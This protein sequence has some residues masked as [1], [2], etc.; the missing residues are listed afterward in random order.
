MARDIQSLDPESI[1]ELSRF[2]AAGFGAA[3]DAEFAAPEILRWKYF[4]PRGRGG[5]TRSF[6]A[7]VDGQIAG[8]IG[9][10]PTTFWAIDGGERRE[11]TGL[12]IIDWLGS[13]EHP[14]VG[15]SLI[16]T[17]HRLAETQFGMGT[18][19][20]AKPV[21][22]VLGYEERARVPI[23]QRVF[24]PSFRLRGEGTSARKL[25]QTGRDLG[26][27]IVR[28]GGRSSHA[29]EARRVGSFGPE[30]DPIV[31]GI[32]GPLV[33]T[34][35]DPELLNHYLRY[36][37]GSTSGWHLLEAGRLRGYGLLNLVRR[38]RQVIGKVVDVVLA[39][40]DPDLWQAALVALACQLESQGAD[41]AQACGTV[42]WVA[43]GLCQSGFVRLHDVALTLRDRN[44]LLPRDAPFFLTFLEGDYAYT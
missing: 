4:D 36:P 23:Y 17:V 19:E 44:A 32:T 39:D 8:H 26:R 21:I 11:V 38:G 10:C 1:P 42:P 14:G 34:R 20:A 31:D 37:R 16:R 24:R 13:R 27:W 40:R 2:L 7:L 28:R 25:L 35:R 18:S 5:T 33:L 6:V 22:R 30:I 3:P 41:A 15:S 9:T 12:H 43:Q 29:L